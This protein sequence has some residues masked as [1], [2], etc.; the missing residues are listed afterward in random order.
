MVVT[1]IIPQYKNEDLLAEGLTI[2][3]STESIVAIQ[4]HHDRQKCSGAWCKWSGVSFFPSP[5]SQAWERWVSKNTND[6]NVL[7]QLKKLAY[8]PTVTLLFCRGN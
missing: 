5:R 3:K 8:A 1:T 6:I 7:E 2:L 4:I